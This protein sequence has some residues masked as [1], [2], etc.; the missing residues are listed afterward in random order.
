MR[1]G[2]RPFFVPTISKDSLVDAMRKLSRDSIRS[3]IVPAEWPVKTKLW[4]NTES[5][6]T[7][8]MGDTEATPLSL[9]ATSTVTVLPGCPLAVI[10]KARVPVSP[11]RLEADSCVMEICLAAVGR[12]VEQCQ[13]R[14]AAC[15]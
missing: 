12:S 8:E 13:D 11:K 5:V 6:K 4:V 14:L 15:T 2:Y 3:L 9:V 10:T 1:Q 7:R